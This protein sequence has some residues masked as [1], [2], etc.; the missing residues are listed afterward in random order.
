[1][2]YNTQRFGVQVQGEDGPI[3]FVRES[4]AQTSCRLA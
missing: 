2:S 3:D 1:L 4:I